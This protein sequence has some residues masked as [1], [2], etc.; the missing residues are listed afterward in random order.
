MEDREVVMLTENAPG[1]DVKSEGSG[2][3]GALIGSGRVALS[4]PETK[5]GV[6]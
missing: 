1:F 6:N 5:T 3:F 4:Y 2:D